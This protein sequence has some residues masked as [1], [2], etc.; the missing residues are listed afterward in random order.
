MPSATAQRLDPTAAVDFYY[1]SANETASASPGEIIDSVEILAPAGI[2]AWTVIY[3]STGLDGE[4]VAVSGLV[5]APTDPPSGSGYPVIAWAHGTTGI[6]DMCAPSRTGVYSA[7][8]DLA[9]SGYVISATDYQGLGT[10]GTHPYIIGVSEGRSVL[11]SIRAAENLPEAHAGAETVVAGLSQGGHAALWAGQLAPA[12]APE[13]DVRGALAGS[14]PADLSAFTTWNFEATGNGQIGTA[15]APMLLYGVWSEAY[16][17][18][19]PFLTDVGQG[20]A[21]AATDGCDP[22]GLTANP[23]VSDPTL[24]PD[25]NQR[26]V[27]NSPGATQ[28]PVP[29]LV[30]SP[31]DDQLVSYDSQVEGV[32]AMCAIGDTVELRTVSGGHDAMLTSPAVWGAALEWIEARFAGATASSTCGQN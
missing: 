12:Y 3:G 28:T 23:Y 25:W 11:D 15:F 1:P 7:P 4:P 31:S 2:R 26:F 32:N 22:S 27:E 16:G 21:A 5:L 13:L 14:P 19:L 24:I 10:A 30:V 29:Y 6:A 17:L 18:S 9:A 20:I 8:I